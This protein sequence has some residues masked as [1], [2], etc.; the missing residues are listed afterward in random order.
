MK[1]DLNFSVYANAESGYLFENVFKTSGS[2][3][4]WK[5]QFHIRYVVL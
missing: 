2:D 3:V 5:E 4:K 1:M